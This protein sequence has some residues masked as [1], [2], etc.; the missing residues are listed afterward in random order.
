MKFK[1]NSE[2]FK[3]L[4]ESPKRTKLILAVGL[5]GIILIMLSEV[6]PDKSSTK[7]TDTPE[8]QTPVPVADE[9]EEYKLR[10]EAQLKELLEQIDGVGECRVMVTLEGTTE[11]IYAENISKYSDND[12]ARTSDKF[13][14]NIVFTEKDGEKQALV[15]K[16]IKPQIIGVVVVCEGGGNIRVN[17]RVLKAVSTALDISSAKIC[18]E[19][20][21][22]Y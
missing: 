3:G 20:K 21:K 16:I 4:A 12:G 8:A 19:A 7:K 2:L 17:E 1:L 18:V 11:Y 9:N 6:L 14:N 15:K 10:T 13:D 22:Q 5:I